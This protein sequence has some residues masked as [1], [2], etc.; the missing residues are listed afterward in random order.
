[1]LITNFLLNKMEVASKLLE[2]IVYNTGPKI[3]EHM[4]IVMGKST[5]E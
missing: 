2:K 4:L 1:M 3:E 5:H